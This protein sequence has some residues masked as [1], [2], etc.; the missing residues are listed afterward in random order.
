MYS[1]GGAGDMGTLK[2][3]VLLRKPRKAKQRAKAKESLKN[4]TAD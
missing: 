1:V 4:E 3:S 2:E